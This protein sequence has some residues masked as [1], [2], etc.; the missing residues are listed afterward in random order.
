MSGQKEVSDK[1]GTMMKLVRAVISVIVALVLIG[2]FTGGTLQTPQDPQDL[3][4]IA[5]AVRS[6]GFVC[7]RPSY[8]RPA[9][10]TERGEQV[11]LVCNEET[12]QYSLTPSPDRK[13]MTIVP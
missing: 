5:K 2:H 6:Q 8:L 11:R 9:G 13:R 10:M 4:I 3:E 7:D 12:L 1:K